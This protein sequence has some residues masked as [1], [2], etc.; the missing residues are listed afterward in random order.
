MDIVNQGSTYV[1]SL[2]FADE[3]GN[4]VTPSSSKYR[5]D[6]EGGNAISGNNAN[7]WI[8]F[9]PSGN[10]YDLTISGNENAMSNNSVSREERIVTVEFKYSADLK[11]QET[12]YRYML[13]R[14][15]NLLDTP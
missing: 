14:I 12:E 2:A 3:N 10:T 11:V 9:T 15:E 13:Q 4:A 5:I 1:L 6:V 8:P 7:A